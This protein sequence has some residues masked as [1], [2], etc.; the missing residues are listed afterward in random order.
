LTLGIITRTAFWSQNMHRH[1]LQTRPPETA[2]LN[3]LGINDLK[4]TVSSHQIGSNFSVLL[5]III[6]I[7]IIMF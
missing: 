6:I 1:I 7:I 4:K 3:L 5:K 2:F